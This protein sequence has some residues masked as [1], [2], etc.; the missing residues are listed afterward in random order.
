MNDQ[1]DWI[2]QGYYCCF[3][4]VSV[5]QD[6]C[7]YLLPLFLVVE[8]VLSTPDIHCSHRAVHIVFRAHK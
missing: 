7:R 3:N 5:L 1:E 4:T 2:F 8:A 6:C